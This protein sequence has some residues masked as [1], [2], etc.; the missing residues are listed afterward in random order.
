MNGEI[1]AGAQVNFGKAEIY[2]P[3]NDQ[4]KAASKINDLVAGGY[5]NPTNGLEPR[6]EATIAAMAELDVIVTPQVCPRLAM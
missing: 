5:T 3:N 1:K 4:G 2:F 6:F